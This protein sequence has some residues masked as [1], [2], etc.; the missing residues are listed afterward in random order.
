MKLKLTILLTILTLGFGAVMAQ[1]QQG[2]RGRLNQE[3][4]K[5][6]FQQYI[7]KQ[8]QLTE[9]EATAFFPIYEECQK[10]KH[11][12][13]E[14][15]W[16]LRR[17]AR[18]K[19]LSEA[20]YEKILEEIAD[21]RI[22]IDQLDKSFLPRYHKVLSYKKIFDVQGAEARFHREL[23]KE[24]NHRKGSKGNSKENSSK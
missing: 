24:A 10:Q 22:Q 3:E 12:K 7:T 9:E 14:R 21:L 13:N 15:I 1:S 4:F 16:K 11:E 6:K 8:A 23:L 17:E 5:A 20:E 18:G 2:K 19:Q